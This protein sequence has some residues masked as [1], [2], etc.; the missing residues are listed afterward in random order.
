MIYQQYI[1]G[2]DGASIAY[3]REFAINLEIQDE[4]LM[5]FGWCNAFLKKEEL[6]Q[7]NK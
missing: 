7:F 1:N 5:D 3:N 2:D 4:M 6:V